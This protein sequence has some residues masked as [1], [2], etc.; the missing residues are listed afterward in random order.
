MLRIIIRIWQVQFCL[1]ILFLFCYYLAGPRNG[2]T[3]FALIAVTI[4]A[5]SI[6]GM[7]IRR[8]QRSR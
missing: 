2:S 5:L 4:L 8:R 7:I 6:A 3:W 1:L